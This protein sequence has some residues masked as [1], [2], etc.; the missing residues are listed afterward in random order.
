MS[1]IGRMPID[2]SNVNVEVKGQTVHYKG[3]KDSGVYELPD[4]FAIKLDGSKLKLT[5][6]EN[7]LNR[8]TN[9]AWGMHRALLAN[10]LKGAGEGFEKQLKI[11][12]LGYKATVA[13]NKVVFSLGYSHKVELPL[14]KEVT[15]EVDKTGQQLTL[16]SHDKELLGAYCDKIRSL[17][18]P[19]PYKG[20]GIRYANEEV[21]RKA[22][23]TKTT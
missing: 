20:T 5:V 6:P 14:P 3:G 19:E 4:F 9:E 10:A 23:K 8:T 13:G 1:K 18:S 2:I 12:G 11:I 16:K 17:R 15:L 22:G 7:K 21:A